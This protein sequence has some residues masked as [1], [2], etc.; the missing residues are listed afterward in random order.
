[1]YLL[2]LDESGTPSDSIFALGGIAVRADR[3][4]EVKERWELCLE[5]CGWPRD[6]ELKWSGT[7]PAEVMDAAYECL[8]SLPVSALVTVLYPE[9]KDEKVRGKFFADPD[10]TYSTAL[11]FIAERYQRFLSHRD[12]W[13][14]IILDSRRFDEDNHMRRYFDRI[15]SDGTDFSELDRIVDGLL[16]GPSHHS[17]GLQLADLVVGPTRK[18]QFA[19]GD[20]SRYFRQLDPIF[21]RHPVDG[22][23][24]G[25]G[26]KIF[27]GTSRPGD[28][29]RLFNPRQDQAGHDVPPAPGQA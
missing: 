1:M 9:T 11:T 21:M 14:V 13:G 4:R 18:A 5:R 23:M 2:F 24:D 27:P 6:R 3:W 7:A 10:T 29:N 8:A 28:D 19:L 15:H 25:T 26:L 22:T 16:L 17:L 20:G 12:S